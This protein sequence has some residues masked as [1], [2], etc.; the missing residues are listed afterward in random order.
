MRAGAGTL[1]ATNGPDSLVAVRGLCKVFADRRPFARATSEVNVLDGVDLV[2]PRGTAMAIV[3]E[4]GAGKSTLARC[5]ALLEQPTRGEIWFEGQKVTMLSKRELLAIRG[6][7]QL[8]FQDPASAL[9]PS[10][11]AEEIV[12]E[13]LVIQRIG[14]PA[15][16]RACV[17]ELLGQVGL[18]TEAAG[19]QPHEFSGGQRQRLAVARALA[20]EPRLLILDEA[21]SGLDLKTQAMILELLANLKTTR[22]MSSIYVS[23]DLR[24]V[25]E[26]ADEIVVM[27]RGRIVE[28]NTTAALFKNPRDTYTRELLAAMPAMETICERRLVGAGR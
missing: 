18:A 5:I 22:R 11:T 10:M 1:K 20:L 16:R 23:H 14:T 26:L 4:S 6:K 12:T 17:M 9:N 19:K 25:S 27:H 24:T 7:V 13:P 2:V 8:I 15:E 3:G 28:Q 21:C